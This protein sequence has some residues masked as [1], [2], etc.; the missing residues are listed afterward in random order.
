MIRIH[1]D[2]ILCILRMG[3]MINWEL[4]TPEYYLSIFKKHEFNNIYF[5]VYPYNINFVCLSF[6]WKC[7]PL[8]TFF[9]DFAIAVNL[10]FKEII[11]KGI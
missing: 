2:D 3:E 7:N 6:N 1:I 4:V 10:M 11:N 9:F 5:L 8:I